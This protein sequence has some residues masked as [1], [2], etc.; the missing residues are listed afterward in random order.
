[1]KKRLTLLSLTISL[2]IFAFASCSTATQ[3][4]YSQLSP[5]PQ[6]RTTI[7]IKTTAYCKCQKCCGW[8]TNW[9]G[10]PVYSSGRLKGKKKIIGQTA[11]GKIAKKGTIAA[12][13]QHFPF[14]TKMFIPGYGHGIVQDRGSAIKGYHLDLYFPSH[15]EAINWGVRY[16]NVTIQP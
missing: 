12:D 9:L 14:K 6:K 10:H 16:V 8:K 7:K 13:T 11:S 15:Q 5:R 4:D 3:F 1:M 2:F